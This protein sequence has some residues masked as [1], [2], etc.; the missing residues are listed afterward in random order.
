MESFLIASS[1]YLRMEKSVSAEK[2]IN[3]SLIT[4]AEPLIGSLDCAAETCN[5]GKC[6]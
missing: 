2:C 6:W 1:N 5:K 4:I 3:V